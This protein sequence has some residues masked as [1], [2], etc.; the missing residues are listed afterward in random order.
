MWL[1]YVWS[2]IRAGRPEAGSE[3][4]LAPNRKPYYDDEELEGRRL[5][6]VQLL[7]LGHAR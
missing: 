4:E 2:N 6:R 1:V 3:I 7:G 5:E